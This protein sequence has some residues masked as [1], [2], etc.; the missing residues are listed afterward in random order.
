MLSKNAH[1]L[2]G[3]A[4]GLA[5]LQAAE[6]QIVPS[7][8]S[9]APAS[10][11]A[12]RASVRRVS[13]VQINPGSISSGITLPS[14]VSK[15][16]KLVYPKTTAKPVGWPAS[17]PWEP[18]RY[19]GPFTKG[20]DFDEVRLVLQG[21]PTPAGTSVGWTVSANFGGFFATVNPAY[22]T[23]YQR[24]LA[25]TASQTPPVPSGS[26][27]AYSTIFALKQISYSS[28]FGGAV[29]LL[30]Q[31]SEDFGMEL[32]S[33]DQ[34]TAWDSPNR[35]QLQIYVPLDAQ[36]FNAPSSPGR[37]HAVLNT[38]HAVKYTKVNN[39]WVLSNS[40]DGLAELEQTVEASLTSQNPISVSLNQLRMF[41]YAF[42]HA[43]LLETFD[44]AHERMTSVLV[45]D[46]YI[47]TET[48]VKKQYAFVYFKMENV[49]VSTDIVGSEELDVT[50][51]TFL[52]LG[53]DQ[54]IGARVDVNMGEDMGNG[55]DTPWQVVATV[56]PEELDY[57]KGNG[58]VWTALMMEER[59]PIVD[60]LFFVNVKYNLAGVS[61]AAVR[62][63]LAANPADAVLDEQSGASTDSSAPTF[64]FRYKVVAGLR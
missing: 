42:V 47:G 60:D 64:V 21:T 31:Q 43:N 1:V 16:Q 3:L 10:A 53:N 38:G 23:V 4:L 17:I 20:S 55:E 12:E 22:L 54:W 46:N 24:Y 19:S 5:L 48:V 32:V 18:R 25:S 13:T 33:N 7:Q 26:S 34:Q 9:N 8:T 59:D 14:D 44:Y 40:G 62:A 50:A 39:T 58:G 6:A 52:A 45:S 61:G 41:A 28:R 2:L 49:W 27:L 11:V 51:N 35:M 36:V 56:S 15:W 29:E 63:A 37:V 57:Y 30:F